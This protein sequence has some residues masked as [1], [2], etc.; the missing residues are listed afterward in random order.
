MKN[1]TYG[2]V[3]RPH[4]LT[5]APGD[6]LQ[7]IAFDTETYL[8]TP[9]MLAPRLVCVSFSEPPH[10][11]NRSDGLDRI[12][13]LLA[14]DAVRLVGH[15]VAYDLGVIAAEDPARF[16]PLIF[17]ALASDRITD[18][19][20]REQLAQ[21][22]IGQLRMNQHGR[23]R[24]DLGALTMRHNCGLTLDK[25]GDS[26]RLH[27]REL[28][29]VP[30]EEY[31]D[32]AKRYAI[33]DALA[34]L[35][36]YQA[37]RDHDDEYNQTR[38]AWALHLMTL[39]GIAIDADAVSKLEKQ[40]TADVAEKRQALAASGLIRKNG[41]KDTKAI[42]AKVEA[43]YKHPPTTPKGATATDRQTLNE[44]GDPDLAALAELGAVDKLLKTYIPSLKRPTAHPSYSLMME[45]G[46]T[47]SSKPNIQNLPRAGGVREC[48]VPRAGYLL[49]SIDYSTLELAALA[50]V[51]RDL[52]GFSEMG[53]AI[54]AGADLHQE[55]ADIAGTSRQTAKAAN[56]GFPAG[57]SAESFAKYARGYSVEVDDPEA[58]RAAWFKRW[59]EMRQ[60]FD[61]VS[62][63]IGYHGEGTFESIKSN[64]RRA[65]CSFTQGCNN[66]FQSRAADGAKAALFRVA[67]ACYVG[68]LAGIAYPIAFIHDEILLEAIDPAAADAVAVIMVDAMRE[69][70]CDIKIEAEPS[71][72][73][74][75]WS[76]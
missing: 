40:L 2:A 42:R 66:M 27:Y 5:F 67:S 41:T 39:R 9:D 8:I 71:E 34:T 28:D 43:A 26:W 29:G 44:S 18:T 32:A 14:D 4:L 45:T 22:A 11:L 53:D 63:Q 70:I 72:P 20:I 76:K 56:F 36:V 46:R 33:D 61:W 37:Q 48:Y 50:Q 25:S 60:Y 68:D 7:I 47:S 38:A 69:W 16:L 54:N 75:R 17:A 62:D 73:M 52:F 65:G 24:Y 3:R 13:Q 10:L 6:P 55:L 12:A 23:T 15:H 35:R 21:L 58:V 30:V 31:P 49:Y 1:E 59:P 19:K 57:M 64:R 74:E 51:C